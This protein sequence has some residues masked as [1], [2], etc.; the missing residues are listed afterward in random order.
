MK[1][2]NCGNRQIEVSLHSG[3]MVSNETPIKECPECTHVWIRD[4][5]GVVKVLKQGY[6]PVNDLAA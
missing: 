4:H 6:D 2:P 1:C 3:G 5:R